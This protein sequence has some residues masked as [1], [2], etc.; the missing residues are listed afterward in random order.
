[1][2]KYFP[3]YNPFNKNFYKSE[4]QTLSI[5]LRKDTFGDRFITTFFPQYKINY[6]T[7]ELDIINEINNYNINFGIISLEV[8]SYFLLKNGS[9]NINFIATLVNANVNILAHNDINIDFIYNG[10]Y[11]KIYKINVLYE[12]SLHH[13]SCKK[14][15]NYLNISKY[16]EF[17]FNTN[18]NAPI[19]ILYYI[20]INPILYIKE[21]QRNTNLHYI[22]ID[23][24]GNDSDF[25]NQYKSYS[26]ELLDINNLTDF[27]PHL[28]IIDKRKNYIKTIK[29]QFILIS[30]NKSEFIHMEELFLLK[31]KLLYNKTPDWHEITKISIIETSNNVFK[32]PYD[33]GAKKYYDKLLIHTTKDDIN[34]WKS[35]SH[36]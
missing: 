3:F 17:V 4:E 9:L 26:I 12:N 18:T 25:V 24:K 7:K 35:M 29:T 32:I 23:F 34:R 36:I 30:N 14:L 31:K 1:M 10:I 27:Y 22:N 21:L 16:F 5:G 19:E 8:L 15:L 11:N 28:T 33:I 20:G 6:K 2:E 13:L